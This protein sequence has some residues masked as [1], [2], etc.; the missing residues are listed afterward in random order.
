MGWKGIERN[1]LDYILTDLLPVEISE[2]FSFSKFYNYLLDKKQKTKIDELLKEIKNAKAKNKSVMFKDSWSSK[3]LKFKILKGNDTFREMSV[4]QPLAALNLF[5]FVECYQKEI[6][7]YF[8]EHH[9]FS[10]RYHSKCMD[11]YYKSKKGKETEY[12]QAQSISSGRAILQQNGSYFKI[13]PFQSINS[14]A[15]SRMWRMANFKYKYFMKMDYK[16]CFD[17][18]YTHAFTW[19]IERIVLDAKDAKN[20][21]LFVTIDRILQNINGRSSNGIVVGPEFSRMIVEL[22]LQHIDRKVLIS[23]EKE[24]IIHN[25]DYRIFRYVDDIFVFATNPTI[26]EKI[27]TQYKNIGEKFLLRFNE[28][29]LTKGE[30]PCLP[31]EWLEK[32]RTL[33]ESIRNLFYQGTKKEF[34][35]LDIEKRSLLKSGFVP[36]DSIKDNITVLMKTYEDDKRT[37]V[38]FLLSTILNNINKKSKGYTLLSKNDYNKA[39]LLLDLTLFIYAFFPSFEQTRKVISIISFLDSEIDFKNDKFMKKK[40]VNCIHRYSFIFDNGNLHDLCD[41]FPLFVEF[42][43]HLNIQ[44]EERIIEEVEQLNDP[45][46]WANLILYSKYYSTF[47]NEVVKRAESN[48]YNQLQQISEREPLM[49]VEFWYV[50]VFHNCPYISKTVI[51]QIDTLINKISN[52]YTETKPSHQ[53]ITIICDFMKIKSSTGKKPEDS[54]FNWKGYSNFSSKITYRT[55][56]KTI[57]RRYKKSSYSL[58]ASID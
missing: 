5:F 51:D 9:D 32:T 7:S 27:Q 1:K 17:S 35:E 2:L 6:L 34:D 11:L 54:F 18:I 23:L 26:L 47:F 30:T 14:F 21:N 16:S 24:N 8:K 37:I 52:R 10:I 39:F 49:Q 28:L 41:W 25:K 29:K 36:I 38:S 50:L 58:Y 42:D 4:I 33:T 56:Q 46:L 22:L 55:Y 31:K 45:I 48:I 53:C 12:F 57:F 44:T 20:S 13:G 40:L 15:D 3:P 43:I 19:I